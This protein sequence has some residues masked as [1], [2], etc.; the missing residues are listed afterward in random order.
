MDFEFPFLWKLKFVRPRNFSEQHNWKILELFFNVHQFQQSF[1]PLFCSEVLALE[2]ASYLV[3]HL[4]Y[5]N[6]DNAKLIRHVLLE[7]NVFPNIIIDLAMHQKN[8]TSTIISAFEDGKTFLVKA[9]NS[10]SNRKKIVN[11]FL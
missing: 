6:S 3:S 10:V 2:D 7:Q 4:A 5:Q 11:R 1:S 8:L 9:L